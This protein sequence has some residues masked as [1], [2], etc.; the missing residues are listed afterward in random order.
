MKEE[1]IMDKRYNVLN[2]VG[3]YGLFHP[4][5]ESENEQVKSNKFTRDSEFKTQKSKNI[6]PD[7]IRLGDCSHLSS[8]K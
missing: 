8:R 5:N 7:S 1:L 4:L 3:D 2:E 6:D